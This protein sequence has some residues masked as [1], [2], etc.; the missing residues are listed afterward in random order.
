[1]P[2]ASNFNSVKWKLSEA[3]ALD[4]QSRNVAPHKLSPPSF[5]RM[6][7]ELEDQQYVPFLLLW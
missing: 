7:L 1:M 3:E 5:V 4:P 2:V 6:G